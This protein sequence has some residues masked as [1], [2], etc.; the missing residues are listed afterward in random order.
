MMAPTYLGGFS[1]SFQLVQVSLSR[2]IGFEDG[3]ERL[4]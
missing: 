2:M 1:R 3:A 4:S